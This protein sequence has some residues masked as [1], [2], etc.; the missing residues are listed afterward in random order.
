MRMKRWAGVSHEVHKGPLETFKGGRDMF[1]FLQT[2]QGCLWYTKMSWEDRL[3]LSV[4]ILA[5]VHKD[6]KLGSN[7]EE[8]KR[9]GLLETFWR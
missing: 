4:I 7:M 8:G 6:L 3:Q 5:K 2:C 1:R 9:G